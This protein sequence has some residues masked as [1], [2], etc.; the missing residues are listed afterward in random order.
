MPLI[1]ETCRS[2]VSPP[3]NTQIF[4]LDGTF[5]FTI[6]EIDLEALIDSGSGMVEYREHACLR[7]DRSM[8]ACDSPT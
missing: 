3:N 2:E 5:S 6:P 8:S 4:C 7:I 1:K